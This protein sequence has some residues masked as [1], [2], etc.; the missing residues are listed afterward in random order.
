[1]R[2][3]RC[4][5]FGKRPMLQGYFTGTWLCNPEGYGN[6]KIY[7]TDPWQLWY[8]HNTTKQVRVYIL[9]FAVHDLCSV[10]IYCDLLGLSYP[11]PAGLLH[12]HCL[13]N[14][15][16]MK[17]ITALPY[18]PLRALLTLWDGNPPFT[19]GFPTQRNS[20]VESQEAV[21]QTVELMM[22]RRL[23]AL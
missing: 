10:V 3:P 11:Y 4:C 20:K 8:K 16:T 14:G 17:R 6:G 21:E 9:W 19:V 1:M 15:V 23:K 12:W 7:H 18:R 5:V 2:N 22:R 13:E